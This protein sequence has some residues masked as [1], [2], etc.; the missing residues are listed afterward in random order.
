[1]HAR[2]LTLAW[3]LAWQVQQPGDAQALTQQKAQV[4]ANSA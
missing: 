2:M 1:M 4:G 3:K